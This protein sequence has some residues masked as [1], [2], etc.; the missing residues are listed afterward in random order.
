[1]AMEQIN[2][3]EFMEMIHQLRTNKLDVSNLKTKAITPEEN[4]QTIIFEEESLDLD[5]I[6]GRDC[7]YSNTCDGHN[8]S[9]YL[10]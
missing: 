1:M 8:T 2:Q 5:D 10:P 7:Q 9:M 6:T 4:L 3:A